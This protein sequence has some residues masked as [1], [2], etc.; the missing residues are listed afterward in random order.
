MEAHCRVT[1]P[2]LN[3]PICKGLIPPPREST[4]IDVKGIFELGKP[5]IAPNQLFPGEADVSNIAFPGYVSI[6]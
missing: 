3:T 5:E 1:E 4:C 6:C 2:K